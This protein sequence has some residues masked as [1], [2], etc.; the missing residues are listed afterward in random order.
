MNTRIALLV[1]A[2]VAAAVVSYLYFSAD[3]PEPVAAAAPAGRA[4]AGVAT[5]A[6]REPATPD[7]AVDAVRAEARALLA[8]V[9]DREAGD[10]ANPWALAHGILARGRDFRAT[11]GRL[12]VHVLVDD[13][14]QWQDVPDIR[15]VPNEGERMEGGRRISALTRVRE[16]AAK[17]QRA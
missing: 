7:P 16:W 4:F 2:V 8:D 14:L 11:D 13:F 6:P 1:A 5:P 10:P 15:R 12:A 9:I 3:P 17:T